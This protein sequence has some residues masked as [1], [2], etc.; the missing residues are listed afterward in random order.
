PLLASRL[1]ASA[2]ATLRFA[3]ALGGEVPHQ[4]HLPALVGDTHADAALGELV[5][6]G[7]VSPV[8][9]RYRLA[10][11]VPAQL[12]AAGYTDDADARI[13]EAAQHYA[14]WTGHPSVTPER[15]CAE[16]DAVLAALA[17]LSPLAADPADEPS[18]AARLAR[19]AAPAFAAGL[20]WSAWERALRAGAEAARIAGDVGEQAYFHHELGIHALCAGQLDRARAELEASIGLRGALADKRGTVAGRRALALVADRSGVPLAIAP[21]AAEEVP[22]AHVEESA[23]PPRGVPMAF[24]DLQPPA[25]TGLVVP[26]VVPAATVPQRTKD[27]VPGGLKGLAKRN[28]VAAGA[29]ALL[30]AVLG[31]VVTLGATS[32]NDPA[33]PS[34]NVGVNP[35]ASQGLDDGSLDADPAAG[36]KGDTGKATSR[37]TD[38]GPDGT[39]GTADDPTPTATESDEPSDEETGSKEPDE[40]D[41]PDEPTPSGTKPTQSQKP[42]TSPSPSPTET[43]TEEPTE[44]PTDPEPTDPTTT[45]GEPSTSNSA[46]GPVSSA[47]METS[48]SATQSTDQASPEEPETMI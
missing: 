32:D 19:T 5:S 3:V 10:A 9:A 1:S 25:D 27:G 22:E 28:L 18:T 40:P 4:A 48:A 41:E 20:H 46:S 17:A 13:R 35:S 30:V 16:S 39:L 29:G 6:C 47:P 34:E 37:P 38:P 21:T 36:N 14:W 7:L 42:P 23:S 26:G 43:E 45:P 2:R 15:V 33:S 24:P 31:T 44:G 12:E 8:G 11:G